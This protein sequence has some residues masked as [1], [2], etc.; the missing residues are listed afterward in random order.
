VVGAHFIGVRK[1]ELV[2]TAT[3]KAYYVDHSIISEYFM[4]GNV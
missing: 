3:M 2:G 4:D 1:E